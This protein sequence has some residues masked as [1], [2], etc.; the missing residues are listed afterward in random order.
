MSAMALLER[1]EQIVAMY[2]QGLSQARI[3]GT[4][5]VHQQRVSEVLRKRGVRTG[6]SHLEG[7]R[8]PRWKGGVAKHG[9]YVLIRLLPDDPLFAMVNRN[10]Y[11]LEH[12]LTIARHLERPLRANETVHHINGISTDNRI[13]NLQL[14]VGRHGKN[15]VFRCLDCG[16]HN[17]ES[18]AL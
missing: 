14:R 17:I 8:H 16:S 4:L 12:R 15:A 2:R 6:L 10:G 11:V 5:H 7:R 1:D 9:E 3:A 18:Q 13:E